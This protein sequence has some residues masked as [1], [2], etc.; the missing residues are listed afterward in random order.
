M[1][2]YVDGSIKSIKDLFAHVI[3]KHIQKQYVPDDVCFI[4]FIFLRI[5]NSLINLINE[6]FHLVNKS[7]FLTFAFQNFYVTAV[8][9]KV[10]FIVVAFEILFKFFEI[11]NSLAILDVF[12][13]LSL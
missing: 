7:N 8:V 5:L 13:T 3:L 9:F 12:V 11:L 2:M 6:N 10:V 4:F 1:W